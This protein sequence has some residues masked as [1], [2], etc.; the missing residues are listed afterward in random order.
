MVGRDKLQYEA[1]LTQH[2]GV[3]V[4]TGPNT[5][6]F[7]TVEALHD[8]YGDRKAN[9]KKTGFTE[10]NAALTGSRELQSINDRTI[11][12][13]RRRTI[14][15]AFSKE[16]L[17]AA[18]EFVI[19]RVKI[20]CSRLGEGCS[21]SPDGWSA[22]RDMQNWSRYLMLDILGDLCFGQSFC[23]IETYSNILPDLV[24]GAMRLQTFVSLL[25]LLHEF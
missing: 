22:T 7:S 8:I 17:R 20:W 15:H 24:A 10:I 1:P 21:T 12:A 5:L 11:H 9:V 18:E 16:S 14:N 6:S 3:I 2:A 13:K 25:T 19:K 23:S 4:R